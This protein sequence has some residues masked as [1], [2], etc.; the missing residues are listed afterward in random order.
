MKLVNY[1]SKYWIEFVIVIGISAGIVG[2]LLTLHLHSSGIIDAWVKTT[3]PE[4]TVLD[5]LYIGI[6]VSIFNRMLSDI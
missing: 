3:T 5:W 2:L 6:F 1:T 4:M